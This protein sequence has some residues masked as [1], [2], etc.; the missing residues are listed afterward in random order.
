MTAFATLTAGENAL[1]LAMANELVLAYSER[2]QALG[3]DAVSNLA[4]GTIANDKTLWLAM[5]TWLESNCT[6]FVDHVSGPLNSGSTAFLNFTLATWRSAAGLNASGFRRSTDGVNFSYG[7]I[8][9]GDVRGPWVFEDLQKGFAALKWVAKTGAVIRQDGDL[10]GLCYG[11]EATWGDTIAEAASSWVITEPVSLSPSIYNNGY[12]QH[13]TSSLFVSGSAASLACAIYNIPTFTTG[14]VD[15]YVKA[16][17]PDISTWDIS[18]FN[19]RSSG[20]LEDKYVFIE[21]SASAAPLIFSR[22]AYPELPEFYD[23]GNGES[24]VGFVVTG[25]L[26]LIKYDFTNS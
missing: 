9:A 6:N 26:G 10:L 24:V 23:P 7:N 19:A 11:E 12:A 3:Q 4:A 14:T 20:L 2:R 18:I 15:L 17:K 1:S 22:I 16:T 25:I 8:Q 13:T 21:S 5:Q